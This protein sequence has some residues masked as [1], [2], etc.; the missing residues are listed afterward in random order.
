MHLVFM[1]SLSIEVIAVVV[2]RK[3]GEALQCIWLNGLF[4]RGGTPEAPRQEGYASGAVV[5]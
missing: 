1:E 2:Q 5:I 4:K 3:I